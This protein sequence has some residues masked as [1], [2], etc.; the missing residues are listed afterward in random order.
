VITLVRAAR[1]HAR[2]GEH[3]LTAKNTKITKMKSDELLHST[4]KA[5]P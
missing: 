4:G 3:F 2:Q 1:A 5:L